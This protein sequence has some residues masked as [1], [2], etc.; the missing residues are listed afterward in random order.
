MLWPC[1][2]NLV[3]EVLIHSFFLLLTVIRSAVH[4][5]IHEE[6]RFLF[7]DA[8]LVPV[9]RTSVGY[10]Y[11]VFMNLILSILKSRR[12]FFGSSFLAW[13][14]LSGPYILFFI[15]IIFCKFV[16][17]G[18][19]SEVVIFIV[20]NLCSSL[21]LWILVRVSLR[22][23]RFIASSWWTCRLFSSS[24]RSHSIWYSQLS[25]RVLLIR[26][27]ILSMATRNV[28][29]LPLISIAL[30]KVIVLLFISRWKI[31]SIYIKIYRL[32][33]LHMWALLRRLIICPCYFTLSA[34]FSRSTK[35]HLRRH[36]PVLLNHVGLF[37]SL[38]LIIIIAWIILNSTSRLGSSACSLCSRIWIRVNISSIILSL[39]SIVLILS[40][41]V[42]VIKMRI[43]RFYK[44]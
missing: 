37:I 9:G 17:I 15:I 29:L 24:S 8:G 44:I 20:I 31:V 27:S 12:L 35:W 33:V 19:L 32:I 39:I 18:I 26:I 36:H 42:F 28:L 25:S 30:I 13:S 7:I 23:I 41:N 11:W 38:I 40:H 5:T 43:W 21:R 34:L 1:V 14:T 22:P 16:F 4:F 2:N 3:V 10:M 6:V